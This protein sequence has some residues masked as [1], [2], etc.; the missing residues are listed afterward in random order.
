MRNFLLPVGFLSQLNIWKMIIQPLLNCISGYRDLTLS[1]VG[2]LSL[3]EMVHNIG[4]NSA[5]V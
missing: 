4:V 1:I 2:S 5:I 3:L